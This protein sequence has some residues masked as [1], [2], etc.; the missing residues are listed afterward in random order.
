MEPSST[1]PIGAW[2]VPR[3]AWVV[4]ALVAVG[5]LAVRIFD[6]PTDFA[7]TYGFMA[8][9]VL[10]HFGMHGGHAGHNGH[11]HATKSSDNFETAGEAEDRHGQHGGRG[12]H[13]HATNSG[14][15]PEAPEEA[16]DRHGGGCCH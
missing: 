13:V 5:I 11:A 7:V 1:H 10:A 2:R 12:G 14:D 8:L 3:I 9:F 15:R 16:N 4:L 6:V